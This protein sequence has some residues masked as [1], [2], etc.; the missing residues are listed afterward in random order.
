MGSAWKI[1]A[2]YQVIFA[3]VF[4]CTTRSHEYH[5][6]I[7]AT[8]RL[9]I[10]KLGKRQ[11]DPST[12][13]LGVIQADK[14][15]VR[16]IFTAITQWGI[17]IIT[18]TL[19]KSNVKQTDIVYVGKFWGNHGTPALEVIQTK[20]AM[21]GITIMSSTLCGKHSVKTDTGPYEIEIGIVYQN[22]MVVNITLSLERL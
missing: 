12:A 14:A 10:C 21:S 5:A 2:T 22:I 3:V 11:A 1:R 18:S 13:D 8:I 20:I 6:S 9:R 19:K 15:I 16:H 17:V 4:F 7:L